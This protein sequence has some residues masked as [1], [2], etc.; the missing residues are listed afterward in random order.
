[1]VSSRF[2][3]VFIIYMIFVLAGCS[4]LDMRHENAINTTHASAVMQA[5]SSAIEGKIVLNDTINIASRT[6]LLRDNEGVIQATIEAIQE[7]SDILDAFKE[8]GSI[9]EKRNGKVHRRRSEKWRD[10]RAY[11]ARAAYAIMQ[12]NE[13]RQ[14]LWQM[15]MSINDLPYSA[16]PFLQSA[17]GEIM[18]DKAKRSHYIE[19]ENGEFVIKE[20]ASS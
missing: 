14:A 18:I 8:D 1:M 6:L 3:T 11:R 5:Y 19:D 10:D 15:F 17:F 7:R 9:I 20:E 12:E 2:L 4:S 13:N 16:R